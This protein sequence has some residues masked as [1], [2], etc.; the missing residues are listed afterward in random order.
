MA[1]DRSSQVQV[2]NNWGHDITNVILRHQYGSKPFDTGTWPLIKKG[3]ASD[4]TLT[5]HWQTGDPRTD[6]W[7]ISFKINGATWACKNKWCMLKEEDVGGLVKIVIELGTM[8][9]VCPVS[10]SCDQDLDGSGYAMANKDQGFYN[11]AHMVNSPAAIQWAVA[12]G[13]NGLEADLIFDMDGNPTLF[14]HGIPSDSEGAIA[15]Y[16]IDLI[17]GPELK[18]GHVCHLV[19]GLTETPA[20]ELLQAVPHDVALF[21]VDSKMDDGQNYEAAGKNV[22]QKLIEY[23]FERGYRG[24]VIVG[25]GEMKYSR[26]IA[27]A[28]AA[29][30]ASP[31]ADRISF[32]FDME[33]NNFMGVKAK[34]D[35]LEIKHPVYGT[36]ISIMSTDVFYDAITQSTDAEDKKEI[37]LTYIWTLDKESSMEQYLLYGARGIM[38]NRPGDLTSIV[39]EYGIPLARPETLIRVRQDPDFDIYGG[40]F[41]YNGEQHPVRWEHARFDGASI[42]GSYTATYDPGGENPPTEVS[43]YQAHVTFKSE[44]PWFKDK[45][46][47]TT[48]TIVKAK[49][50]I[51]WSAP[52]AIVQGT[53]LGA[54]Q[55]NA[56]SWA[57]VGGQKMEVKGSA[58]YFWHAQAI[59]PGM[60]LPAGLHDLSVR[61]EPNADLSAKF[62][63]A[64]GS[65]QLRVWVAE[66]VLGSGD[67]QTF[68]HLAQKYYGHATPHYWKW[69]IDANKGI[70]PS[71]YKLTRPGTKIH[72]PEKPPAPKSKKATIELRQL[73]AFAEVTASALEVREV[74]NENGRNLRYLKQGD[75]IYLL[76]TWTN[77]A[78]DTWGGISTGKPDWSRPLAELEWIAM[79]FEGKSFIGNLV[80]G[81]RE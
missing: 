32:T 29:A 79:T 20:S 12:Q 80:Y 27:A 65:V 70:I 2:I 62:E 38:T 21:I 25:V 9:V 59:T 26:Y 61:I 73:S 64:T 49:P 55:L 51:V 75:K 16:A 67:D 18:A 40:E 43:T 81:G 35:E 36:G 30:A 24:N 3:S 6:H 8:R 71:D 14:K 52:A 17:N 68:S 66:E 57:N 37:G 48:I 15:L 50:E 53:P 56:S 31:Y 63:A 7:Y 69:I 47:E 74:P 23:L 45:T 42:A 28:A 60:K 77:E 41:A 39:K 78:G 13:A 22:I 19:N 5:V 33:G 46:K 34:L 44:D 4:T 72:I 11:I 76:A 58:T 1:T 10:S 54:K